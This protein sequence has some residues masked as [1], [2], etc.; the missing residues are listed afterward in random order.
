MT[1][2]EREIRIL[3]AQVA[4]LDRA[5]AWYANPKSWHDHWG[6][7]GVVKPPDY[8]DPGGKARRALEKARK[9]K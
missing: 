6:L 5:L 4:T 8:F 9:V 3:K 1:P 2:Q 7:R